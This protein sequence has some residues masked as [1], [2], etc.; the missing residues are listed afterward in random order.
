MIYNQYPENWK[1]IATRVKDE[2]GWKCIRCGHAHDTPAGYMLTVHHLD[3]NK[4][5]CAWWNLVA[6]CQRCHLSV[7][8]RV[9]MERPWIF[10]HTKWFKPYVAGYYAFTH[11][12]RN[13]KPFV[14]ANME[15]LLDLGRPKLVVW[16]DI[17]DYELP[18]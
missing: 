7:Q 10:E 16:G 3:G 8:A 12:M 1:E 11:W 17:F 5:N 9:V 13:D 18:P 15:T 4:S 14:I 2:A 6:L